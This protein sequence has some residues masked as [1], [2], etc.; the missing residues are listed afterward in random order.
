MNW[1]GT[2]P[3]FMTN[4]MCCHVERT[5]VYQTVCLLSHAVIF[6]KMCLSAMF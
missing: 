6:F 2:V 5:F 3:Y 1:I 4:S